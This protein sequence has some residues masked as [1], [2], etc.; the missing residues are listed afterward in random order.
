MKSVLQQIDEALTGK[1]DAAELDSI[2]KALCLEYLGISALSYYTR[3]TLPPNTERDRLLKHALGRLANGE[4]LQYVLGYAPFCGLRFNVNRNVLI[5]RPE[6]A[7]LVDWVAQ[8]CLGGESILDI[9]TGS[10][11]I[12][13]TLSHLMPDCSVQA[14]DISEDALDVARKNNSINGTSVSFAR[15]D[16]LSCE[17]CNSMFNV[18]VSNPP[19]VMDSERSCMEPTVLDYEPHLALF[20]PDADPLLFYKAIAMLGIKALKPGGSLYFEINPMESR[21]MREMLEDKGYHDV[22]LRTDIFGKERMI[23]AIRP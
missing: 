11:C 23:K 13:V 10:G 5:P 2:R 18:I 21:A 4:P 7:E 6:T 3:D 8:D 20:V 14:W 9:G 12:A 15:K 22:V 19:Y 1:I 16:V 17:P